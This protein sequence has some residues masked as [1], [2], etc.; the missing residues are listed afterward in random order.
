MA[1]GRLRLLNRQI[2][3]TQKGTE[4]KR[5]LIKRRRLRTE[6]RHSLIETTAR[7]PGRTEKVLVLKLTVP[8]GHPIP[9]TTNLLVTMPSWHLE[10]VQLMEVK[11]IL[12][13]LRISTGMMCMADMECQSHPLRIQATRGSDRPRAQPTGEGHQVTVDTALSNKES[14]SQVLMESGGS[15]GVHTGSP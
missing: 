12:P 4:A 11:D 9:L 15:H 6:T 5:E 8:M 10:E 13:V 7:T 1:K 2:R 3:R 14:L